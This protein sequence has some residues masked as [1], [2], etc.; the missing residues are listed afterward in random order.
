MASADDYDE[1]LRHCNDSSVCQLVCDSRVVV[2]GKVNSDHKIRIVNAVMVRSKICVSWCLTGPADMK[3]S[4]DYHVAIDVVLWSQG[5][6]RENVR[7]RYCSSSS[8][9]KSSLV[10]S[11]VELK[12]DMH[13]SVSENN[14]CLLIVLPLS[15]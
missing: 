14:F 3:A 10:T 8:Q 1:V 4:D 9:T 5:C 7:F 2:D 6:F 11:R 12:H 13:A 15:K